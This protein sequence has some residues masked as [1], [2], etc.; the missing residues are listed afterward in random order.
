MPP[1]DGYKGV[2]FMKL[3]DCNSEFFNYHGRW[4]NTPEGKKS[5][6][7]RPYVEFITDGDFAVLFA[8]TSGGL[9]VTL[10]GETVTADGGIYKVDTERLVRVTADDASIPLV[11][12]GVET[13]GNIRLAPSRK[14]HILFI[15]DSLTHSPVSHS[16]ILPREWDCDYTCIAQ[17]GMSLCIGRGYLNRPDRAGCEGMS[18]AFFK[19]QNPCEQGEMTDYDFSQAETPGEIFIN[20]GTNDHLTDESYTAEF[21]NKYVEFVGKVR[22]LYGK[23]NIYLLL[24]AA[25]TEG[26]YRRDTIEA[27]AKECEE[28]YDGVKYISSRAWYVEI[29]EDKVHPTEQ[30]YKTFAE[31]LMKTLGK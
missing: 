6:W 11:F 17:G 24:P 18:V 14:R 26:G 13:D 12:Q 4:E 22:A 30:G 10:N 23:A 1:R 5:H 29:S 19:L 3:I 7:V 20:I 25:D 27:S 21:K 31:E 28:K 15:G 9:T 16:V 8:D 2:V